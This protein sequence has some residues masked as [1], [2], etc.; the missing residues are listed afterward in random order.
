[1]RPTRIRDTK[2]ENANDIVSAMPQNSEIRKSARQMLK[3]Q[4][5][6]PVLL[7]V[8]FLLVA[9]LVGFLQETDHIGVT[10]V[11]V[12]LSI[13]VL[14]PFS[15]GYEIVW[16][17]FLRKGS[18]EGVFDDF[19]S[20]YKRMGR[21]IWVYI[22]RQLFTMLWMLLLIVPGVIKSY[23]Y[24]MT[25]FIAKDNPQMGA[26]ECINRSMVMMEGNKMKLFLLD[27]SFIGWILLGI[28]SLGIGMFWI[29]P[30]YYSSRAKF[31]EELKSR[32]A[33]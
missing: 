16:L 32:S 25:M 7:T 24:A 29:L 2:M 20:V 1:M 30:Y 8:L 26:N 4:W 3:G 23:S 22:L 27:L 5:T 28:L 33:C 10:L 21:W 13:L 9:V 31:Y 14:I 18:G 12:A 11:Y 6:S 15:V 17:S 19:F